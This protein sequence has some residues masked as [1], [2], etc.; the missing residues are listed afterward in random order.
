MPKNDKGGVKPPSVR[1]TIAKAMSSI[2]PS[3]V[4]PISDKLDCIML[5]EQECSMLQALDVNVG[6]AKQRLADLQLQIMILEQQRVVTAQAAFTAQ[7]QLVELMRGTVTS[8]GIDP[9]DM[10]KRWHLDPVKATITRTS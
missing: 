7:S 1:E 10:S 9:D 8:H 2:K 5:T 6:A 4:T 3:P